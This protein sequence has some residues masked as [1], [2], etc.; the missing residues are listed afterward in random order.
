MNQI[1]DHFI[2]KKVTVFFEKGADQTVPQFDFIVETR[3]VIGR[4]VEQHLKTG[5]ETPFI[6]PVEGPKVSR[7]P[8]QPKAGEV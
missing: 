2:I 7:H 8:Y 4:G 3:E 1:G 6:M 5:A